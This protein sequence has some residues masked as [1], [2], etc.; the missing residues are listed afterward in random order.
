MIVYLLSEYQKKEIEG[1]AYDEESYFNPIQDI[2]DQ[3]V[4]SDEEV[5]Q[6]NIDWIKEL[7]KIK[8]NPKKLLNE[9][10]LGRK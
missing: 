6:S 10:V 9:I 4:I 3:W 5:S 2:N 1:L 8:F 7:P